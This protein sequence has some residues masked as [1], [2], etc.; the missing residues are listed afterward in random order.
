MVFDF[1]FPSKPFSAR[2]TDEGFVVE[3]DDLVDVQIV[4]GHECFPAIWAD[5]VPYAGMEFLMLQEIVLAVESFVALFATVQPLPILVDFHVSRQG[6]L[7]GEVLG[8]KGTCE[9][10]LTRVHVHVFVQQIFGAVLF[11]ADLTRPYLRRGHVVLVVHSQRSGIV[12][13]DLANI[14]P[15]I[16]QLLCHMLI[17]MLVVFRTPAENGI[18]VLADEDL[19]V[20]VVLKVDGDGFHVVN[21]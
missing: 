18:A 1:S 11:L 7:G 19:F 4:L 13:L 21:R 5:V 14:A 9:R 10:P 17:Q 16:G 2:S 8:T 12:E 3:V 6:V 15:E 20:M